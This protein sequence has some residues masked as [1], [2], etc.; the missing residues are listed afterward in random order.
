MEVHFGLW[1]ITILFFSLNTPRALFNFYF[2]AF[3]K[4]DIDIITTPR[5]SHLTQLP[6]VFYAEKSGGELR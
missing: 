1:F 2:S 4:V 3:L 5:R 6:I